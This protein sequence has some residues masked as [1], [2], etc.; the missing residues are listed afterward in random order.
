M[1]DQPH[2]A[3]FNFRIENEWLN[4]GYN[5]ST[6]RDFGEVVNSQNRLLQR[7]TDPTNR[8]VDIRMLL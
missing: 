1:R 4:G 3:Q 7:W 8:L 2:L 6:V 5:R